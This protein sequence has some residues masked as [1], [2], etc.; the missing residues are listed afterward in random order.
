MLD[1]VCAAVEEELTFREFALKYGSLKPDYH[2]DEKSH[3]L[4]A[5]YIKENLYE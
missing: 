5:E 1:G 4:F 2:P 3:K